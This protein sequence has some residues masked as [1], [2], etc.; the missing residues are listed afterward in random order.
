MTQ[1]DT[2]NDAVGREIAPPRYVR[3]ELPGLRILRDLYALMAGTTN[4]FG[5]L[6]VGDSLSDISWETCGTQAQRN[7]ADWM[8]TAP[9]WARSGT[10][11]LGSPFPASIAASTIY[12][13]GG[14]YTGTY[15]EKARYDI[16]F[17]GTVMSLASGQ[18]AIFGFGGQTLYGD[19]LL[20]PIVTGPTGGIV[21]VR[22]TTAFQPVVGSPWTDPLAG[23]I[24]S[25]HTLTGGELLV[26]T[27]S[28]NPGLTMV[29]LSFSGAPTP[30]SVRL[31]HSSGGDVLALKCQTA[32]SLRHRSRPIA[33]PP[34]RTIS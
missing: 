34:P 3:P 10:N 13:I 12:P 25:G 8:P 9:V 27:H 23:Q 19:Y 11:V 2:V 30:L 6:H 28:A 31:D 17:D 18:Y 33:S 26:D 20:I 24:V 1:I 5:I 14:K 32:V 16:A 4:Q 21:R 15:Y 29:R 7:I 22:Y